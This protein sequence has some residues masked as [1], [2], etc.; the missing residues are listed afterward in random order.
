MLVALSII[1][2]VLFFALLGSVLGGRSK[3]KDLEDDIDRK[4]VRL[5][6]NHRRIVDLTKQR[7]KYRTSSERYRK[8]YNKYRARYYHITEAKK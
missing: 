4:D 2:G 1:S 3:I 6:D 8:L 5:Y 7:S